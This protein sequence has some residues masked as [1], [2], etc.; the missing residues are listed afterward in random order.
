MKIYQSR[1]YNRQTISCLY[2]P[3]QSNFNVVEF[4]QA[5]FT[6]Q[7]A[8]QCHRI[9]TITITDKQNE[10][11]EGSDGRKIT[12]GGHDSECSSTKNKLRNT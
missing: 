12:C 10:L 9:L 8:I 6:P 5:N 1:A 2:I 3:L 11:P 4:E 7:F